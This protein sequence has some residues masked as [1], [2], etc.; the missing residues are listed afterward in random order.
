MHDDALRHLYDEVESWAQW[1]L[2]DLEPE[3][4]RAPK[5][6]RDAVHG[7]HLM[8]PHEVA[9]IDSPLLQRLRHIHQTALAYLVYPTANHTR[10]DHSLGVASVAAKMACALREVRQAPE[11]SLDV[12][13]DLR[14]AGLLHDVGSSLFSHLSEAIIA[15]RYRDMF[16]DIKRMEF[17]GR[18]RFFQK[19]EVGEII[20]YAIVTC[21]RTRRFLL[22][23][24]HKHDISDD[25][26]VDRVAG[27]IVGQPP[28]NG[29]QFMADIINGPF[30][31][32]KIDYLLR[33]CHFSGIRADVD[34]ERIYYTLDIIRENGWSAYLTVQTGGI[35]HLEQVL[36]AKMML[37]TG[38]YHHHKIRT[39]ECMVRAVFET[40]DEDPDAISAEHL[41]FRSIGDFL[42]V[43]EYDW[44]SM[45]LREQR[46]SEPVK[47]ILDRRLLKRAL[48]ISRSTIQTPTLPLLPEL[49]ILRE[50][51]PQAVREL[52]DQIHS[53]LPQSHRRGVRHLWI[54]IPPPPK[55]DEDAN[56]CWVLLDGEPKPLSSIFPS[57]D[58]LRS[59]VANK[60]RAHV[61]Y[62]SEREARRVAHGVAAQVLQ[63]RFGLRFNRLARAP[64]K[65]D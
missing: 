57:A 59:Y 2:G 15:D 50:Q 29:L 32:D 54:D 37:Y 38:I 44:F 49:H 39:L 65:L 12:V 42:K 19:A 23:A 34:P 51:G 6:L 48:V 21:P 35:P 47:Q 22:E 64:C 40:I 18:G 7:F 27:L 4:V 24:L 30:D 58:W 55:I 31:A 33:D 36:L 16:S 61:F 63:D 13:R 26:I 20:S 5:V 45:G 56:N 41:K 3:Y 9:I 43:S 11:V 25:D 17:K 46:L 10:F 62:V 53:A 52:R 60:W 1:L 14:L 28:D 8:A